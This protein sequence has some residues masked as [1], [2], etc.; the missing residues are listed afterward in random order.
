M[1]IMIKKVK[2]VGLIFL[3][4]FFTV[5]FHPQEVSSFSSTNIII[6]KKMVFLGDSITHSGV[7]DTLN[8][9]FGRELPTKSYVDYIRPMWDS[10]FIIY[11]EGIRGDTAHS[12]HNRGKEAITNR[13]TQYNPDIVF[14][15]L[16]TNDWKLKDPELFQIDYNFL[17]SEIQAQNQD[18]VI[19]LLN[20][21]YYNDTESRDNTFIQGYQDVIINIAQDYNLVYLDVWNLTYDKSCE[22]FWRCGA[23]YNEIGAEI[24]G[25]YIISNKDVQELLFPNN[26]DII[27]LQNNYDFPIKVIL[28]RNGKNVSIEIP[29]LMVAE[30][31]F[32]L[33]ESYTIIWNTIEDELID[34]VDIIFNKE[35]LIL[36]FPNIEPNNLNIDNNLNWLIII[37][38]III[39]FILGIFLKLKNGKLND[40]LSKDEL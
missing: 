36:S 10:S 30:Y 6:R 5:L 29:S 13:V 39:I 22:Y 16:G 8:I 15:A 33:N 14:I 23:H 31:K 21:P 26:E 11:N 1:V 9:H 40:V 4:L 19:I 24:V 28:Q 25:E 37:V 32:I 20:I 35:N 38:I 3:G 7:N 12:I 27:E 2:L 17:I 34:S 18:V